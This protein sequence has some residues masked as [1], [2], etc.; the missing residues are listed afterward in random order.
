MDLTREGIARNLLRN[1]TVGGINQSYIDQ[2]NRIED[3]I[4]N[5]KGL[6]SDFNLY[7]SWGESSYSER[8]Y[9]NVVRFLCLNYDLSTICLPGSETIRYPYAFDS[10]SRRIDSLRP[11][12]AIPDELR[13]QILLGHN[14]E[15]TPRFHFCEGASNDRIL[16]QIS[17]VLESGKLIIRPS[18]ANFIAILEPDGRPIGGRMFEGVESWKLEKEIDYY[19]L[20]RFDLNSYPSEERI[21][22]IALPFIAD[23]PF[24]IL[25][26]IIEDEEDSLFDMRKELRGIVE[27]NLELGSQEMIRDILYPRIHALDIKYKKL[28]E[29]RS[30]RNLASYGKVIISLFSFVFAPNF[31]SASSLGDNS[32]S[33][34]IEK[35]DYLEARKSIDPSMRVLWRLNRMN[36]TR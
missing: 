17:P 13:G 22:R 33:A 25:L 6:K 18:R 9:L 3:S 1:M 20:K 4:E 34:I 16:S 21:F 15:I 5:F 11:M 14:L 36:T 12:F 10:Q 28:L 32:L 23:V 29:R 35:S 30:M 19:G 24:S 31:S 27:G 2:F 8:D 26:K 7:Y